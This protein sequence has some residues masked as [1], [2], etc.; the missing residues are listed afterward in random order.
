MIKYVHTHVHKTYAQ[1]CTE[2]NYN[3]PEH[4]MINLKII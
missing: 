4:T 2:S 1:A 3:N